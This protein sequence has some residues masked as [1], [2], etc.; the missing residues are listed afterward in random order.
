MVMV[1]YLAGKIINRILQ[2]DRTNLFKGQDMTHPNNTQRHDWADSHDPETMPLLLNLHRAQGLAF[3][4]ARA[5][6]ARHGLTPA[7][8]DVLATLRNS[9]PPRELTPSELRASVVITSGGLTKVMQQLETRR[10]VDRSQQ[11]IDQRVKPVKL[12]QAGKRLVEK[13]MTELAATSGTWVRNTLDAEEIGLLTKL[14]GKF[15]ETVD[16]EEE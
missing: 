3:F 16:S 15:C 13:V 11:M 2:R 5:I 6:W 12:T 4:R 8:F 10:L 7:E 1:D 9:P 14:L